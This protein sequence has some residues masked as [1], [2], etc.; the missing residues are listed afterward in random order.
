MLIAGGDVN[1]GRGLGKKLLRDPTYNPFRKI[2]PLL[3]QAD[4]RF[5]NLESQ[6]SDQNGETQSPHNRLIFTGPPAGADILALGKIDLVSVAN[7]HAWDYGKKALFET[8]DNLDRV[9]VAHVGAVRKPGDGAYEPQVVTV[10]GW[11]VAFFAV[12]H[13]WNQGPINE[14]EGRLYVAWA[15]FDKLGPQ[16]KKAKQEHDLVIVSYHG[17]AEYIDTP[18]QWTR[19]FVRALMYAGVD[20]VIGHHPHVPQG[21]AWHEGRPIVY[22]LGNLVFPMHRDHEWTGVSYLARFTFERGKRTKLEACPYRIML[23]TPEFFSGKAKPY[24]ERNFRNHLFQTSRSVG[25]SVLD[26]NT[27]EFGCFEVKPS[28]RKL[29]IYQ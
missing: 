12:T 22:S 16:I 19:R 9:T 6:L 8:F 5:V 26:E 25:G 3:Q 13:I 23:Y 17:G 21:V 28:T 4:L 2:A 18:M 20:A 1:L 27:D 7:N 24:L 14:H 29:P 10:N 15:R 11:S